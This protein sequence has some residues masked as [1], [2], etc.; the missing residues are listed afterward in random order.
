MQATRIQKA[1]NIHVR[2]QH[3]HIYYE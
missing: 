2:Q 3:K 1:L